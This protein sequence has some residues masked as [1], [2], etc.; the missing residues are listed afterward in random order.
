MRQVL[1]TMK[2]INKINF[3]FGIFSDEHY[4]KHTMKNWGIKSSKAK[5]KQHKNKI[6]HLWYIFLIHFWVLRASLKQTKWYKD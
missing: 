6:K 5:Q 2:I 1:W 4:Q 3:L